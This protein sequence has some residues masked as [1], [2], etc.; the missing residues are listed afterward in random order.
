[1]AEQNFPPPPK[2]LEDL[3]SPL[4]IANRQQF[5]LYYISRGTHKIHELRTAYAEAK[6][7]YTKAFKQYKFD[8]RGEG[9]TVGDRDDAAQLAN[10]DLYTEMVKAELLV[11]HAVDK[12]TDLRDEL[13]QTQS[14]A[15]LII[16]EIGLTGRMQ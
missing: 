7:A 15:K 8:H 9:G 6:D 16:Q 10:W 4:E 12:R 1:M 14:E 3:R 13:S 5:L 2:P 11:Q